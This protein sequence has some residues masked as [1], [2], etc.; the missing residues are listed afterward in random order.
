MLRRACKSNAGCGGP[1]GSRDGA[2]AADAA[3]VLVELL[4]PEHLSLLAAALSYPEADRTCVLLHAYVEIQVSLAELDPEFLAN[5][6]SAITAVDFMF[7]HDLQFRE[8]LV[9]LYGAQ[10][11]L[12]GCSMRWLAME[13][14]DVGKNLSH[15]AAGA[16]S[17]FHTRGFSAL[18]SGVR[19]GSGSGGWREK[20]SRAK[21]QQEE[22]EEGGRPW[23]Q[24]QARK[25][26]SRWDRDRSSGAGTDSDDDW[27]GGGSRSRSRSVSGGSTSD[28]SDSYSLYNGFNSDDEYFSRKLVRQCRPYDC[29]YGPEYARTFAACEPD[30]GLQE[31][32]ERVLEI[33]KKL[34]LLDHELYD[35]RDAAGGTGPG[36][37]SSGFRFDFRVGG[38]G[39]GADA[40]EGSAAL[41][42]QQ[43]PQD[44]Q[45]QQQQ[46]QQQP[47][48]MCP[49]DHLRQLLQAGYAHLQTTV[50]GQSPVP[51]L[52]AVEEVAAAAEA[53]RRKQERERQRLGQ[54]RRQRRKATQALD[55]DDELGQLQE[56][57]Q[58]AEAE[59]E[60]E[61]EAGEGQGTGEQHPDETLAEWAALQRRASWHHRRAFQ[62]LADHY[63]AAAAE[64]A[65]V[66]EEAGEAEGPAQ[67]TGGGGAEPAA[68]GRGARG[69]GKATRL[70]SEYVGRAAW[71][72]PSLQQSGQRPRQWHGASEAHAERLARPKAAEVAEALCPGL[73]AAHLFT[74]GALARR[75]D[76]T[77]Q[78]ALQRVLGLLA[79]DKE[80]EEGKAI[81]QLAQ[82][83]KM[84]N[85]EKESAKALLEVGGLPGAA[86][87]G[88]MAP[89]L[90]GLR[91]HE[92][93]VHTSIH[94]H[95]LALYAICL[96]RC[97]S[98]L[99]HVVTLMRR[100]LSGTCVRLA[101]A[102][103][104][105]GAAGPVAA[106][107]MARRR[108]PAAEPGQA[109]LLRG[110]RRRVH[111][112]AT[113]GGAANGGGC[114]QRGRSSKE[115]CVPFRGCG[116]CLRVCALTAG[117]A[118]CAPSVYV[119]KRRTRSSAGGG[120]GLRRG[121][122]A[123]P[124]R[125]SSTSGWQ[126]C[127]RQGE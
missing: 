91:I 71:W 115:C 24:P 83:H 42:H 121:A 28:S 98:Q 78:V 16:K 82:M 40:V 113:G 126:P 55:S 114:V 34:E 8:A 1:R 49:A 77:E 48:S 69:G 97:C 29:L 72:V 30:S 95:T 110:G 54:R 60:E 87:A 103:G 122:L 65:A 35:K 59:T 99:S 84:A 127:R 39:A 108:L 66:E 23:G 43:A 47:Q 36:G 53:R 41:G 21:A 56:S 92:H 2:G 86:W 17:G 124:T 62:V 106:A 64:A 100:L 79:T 75:A 9:D 15:K 88:W 67:Q 19:G 7:Q 94:I 107:A 68:S 93:R 12:L 76:A 58:E 52:Q 63:A 3:A 123:P 104:G 31:H 85:A 116:A 14:A 90:A 25:Q 120:A 32:V 112:P 37:S 61:A 109:V 111:V 10:A 105:G 33:L 117:C 101:L 118:A 89:A 80:D 13:E 44:Q 102:G 22:Q 70:L 6:D 81:A 125:H 73:L 119:C 51:Q 20:E 18:A 5:P 57:T 26:A 45:Q 96:P 74:W 38:G 11:A 27:R 4:S 46:Q 50:L